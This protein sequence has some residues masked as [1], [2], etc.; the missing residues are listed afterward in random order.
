[1]NLKMNLTN[2]T[3]TEKLNQIN[4]KDNTILKQWNFWNVFLELRNNLNQSN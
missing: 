1:M 2:E 4:Q 3:I